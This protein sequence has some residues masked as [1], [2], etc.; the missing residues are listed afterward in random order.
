MFLED[1]LFCSYVFE[2]SGLRPLTEYCH[3]LLLVGV[4]MIA[5]VNIAFCASLAGCFEH[6]SCKIPG[7]LVQGQ[8]RPKAKLALVLGVY[9]T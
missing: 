1:I 2:S 8:V 9:I 7:Q 4:L 3:L 5:S 6:F